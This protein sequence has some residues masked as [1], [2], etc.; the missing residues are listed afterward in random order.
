MFPPKQ[1]SFGGALDK[2]CSSKGSESREEEG[3]TKHIHLHE[4]EDWG[5]SEDVHS[6]CSDLPLNQDY[7]ADEELC[8][9]K[10][11]QEQEAKPFS[12]LGGLND[13]YLDSFSP[14]FQSCQQEI[15][16]LESIKSEI[17]ELIEPQDKNPN[18]E[19]L[20][21]FPPASFTI[22]RN[23]QS[24]FR[25]LKGEKISVP[26]YGTACTKAGGRRLSIDVIIRLAGEKFIQSC[27]QRVDD[28]SLLGHPFASSFTGLSS[29]EIRDVELVE[30]LLASTEKVSQQQ[31]ERASKLLN[32]CHEL[33]LDKVNPVQRLVHS[34]YEALREKV[35]LQAGRITSKGSGKQQLFDLEE[36]VMSPKPNNISFHKEVP[37]SQASQYTGMQAIAENVL[38]AKRVHII[39]LVIMNGSH[40]IVLMQALAARF[41]C[42]L[43][44][45]K[46]TAV[47]TKSKQKI[48]DT[49]KRLMTFAQS[50]RLPFSFNVVMVKDFLDLSKNL[51]KLEA[52]EAVAVHSS[53]L[54][55]TMIARPNRLECLM[56]VIKSVN[57]CIMVV[58]EGEANLNSP[59]FV[60]RFT[61]ALFFYGTLFDSLEDC[62][63]HDGPNRTISESVYFN[64]AIRNVVVAEGEERTTRHVNINVWRAFF[65]R[66]GMEEIEL[67]K[68]SL[69]Q[70]KL[71]VNKFP[72]GRSCTLDMDGKCL[73]IGWKGTPVHSLS[74]W[75]FM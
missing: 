22:L 53:H 38:E 35:D 17:K 8:L 61:E 72:R 30:C 50:M 13:L 31:F 51:F 34:F 12:F 75:K 33:C 15:T 10:P 18:E 25:Q 24:R 55:S 68:S 2:Y 28:L 74:A 42:P 43:E 44:H 58:T 32:R 48:E 37:F 4:I 67:G 46:I 14:P 73:L 26:S 62:M 66:F 23:Y 47:G 70:A 6:F 54:F 19:K 16:K 20:N 1:S 59:I 36:A 56:R 21:A 9:F 29:K 60:S 5:G 27:S 65:A 57:P 49:G 45:L 39:D 71:V 52:E 40:C 41:E 3:I 7:T 64:Q 63:N 11:Q 69:Y